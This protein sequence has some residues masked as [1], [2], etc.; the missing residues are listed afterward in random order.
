LGQK[1]DASAVASDIIEEVAVLS[2]PRNSTIDDQIC[3]INFPDSPTDSR[4]LQT[5]QHET[6]AAVLMGLILMALSLSFLNLSKNASSNNKSLKQF[7][8]ALTLSYTI[9]IRGRSKTSSL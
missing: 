3:P 8:I 7:E 1:E 2:N 4:E 6:T 5:L 9:T